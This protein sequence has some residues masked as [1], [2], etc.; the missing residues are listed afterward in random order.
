MT[1]ILVHASV[2]RSANHYL[3]SPSSESYVA[4]SMNG[5]PP[6]CFHRTEAA[7]LACVAER[8]LDFAQSRG[9][10]VSGRSRFL[11]VDDRGERKV[12]SCG[13]RARPSAKPPSA[14]GGSRANA[15]PSDSL[16]P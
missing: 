7:A 12:V 6:T 8:E 5:R 14:V 4:V 9:R 3:V 13:R 16:L 15:L 11:F 2:G 10:D 1:W